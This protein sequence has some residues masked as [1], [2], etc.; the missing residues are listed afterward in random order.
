MPCSFVKK[1]RAREFLKI[2]LYEGS[3]FFFRTSILA[4][5]CMFNPHPLLEDNDATTTIVL[6]RGIGLRSSTELTPAYNN[7]TKDLRMPNLPHQTEYSSAD[8]LQAHRSSTGR[9]C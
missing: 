6:Y 2:K 1:H 3:Q 7:R 4:L 5:D 9:I 8:V